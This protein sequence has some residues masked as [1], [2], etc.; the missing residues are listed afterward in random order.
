MIDYNNNA[1]TDID[2]SQVWARTALVVLAAIE[3]EAACLQDVVLAIAR[4]HIA[5]RL[6]SVGSDHADLAILA[7][8]STLL[9][10]E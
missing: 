6:V 10:L 3:E 9:L 5:S 7:V 2:C 8:R 4:P 1:D